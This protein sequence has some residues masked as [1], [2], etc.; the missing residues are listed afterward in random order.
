MNYFHRENSVF[1]LEYQTTVTY[2]DNKQGKFRTETILK[3]IYEMLNHPTSAT[4]RKE[5]TLFLIKMIF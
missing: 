2:F 5:N 1:K 3:F 4:T